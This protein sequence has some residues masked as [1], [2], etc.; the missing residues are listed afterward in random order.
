MAAARTMV[1]KRTATKV[2]NLNMAMME[3]M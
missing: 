1:A 3:A 2:F